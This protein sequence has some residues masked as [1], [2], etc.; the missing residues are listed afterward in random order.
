MPPFVGAVAMKLLFGS[1]GS[2]NLILNDWFGFKIPFMEGLNGVIFVESIHYFPFILINL[3]TSL[4]NIDRT[5][6][7]SAQNLGAKG[8]G[9]FR[10]IVLPLSMPGYVAGASLVFLK[11]FD[12]LGTPLLLDVNTM[13]APQAYLRISSIGI[14]DPM[15]Y[16]IGVILVLTSVSAVWVAKHQSN[17]QLRM[18]FFNKQHL[19]SVSSYKPTLRFNNN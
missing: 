18:L 7:E 2:I 9:L 10:R 17:I 16:V 15:G 19:L 13:L 3:I 5:M 8:F 14:N 11:V 1:N 12:D 4:N 6:E